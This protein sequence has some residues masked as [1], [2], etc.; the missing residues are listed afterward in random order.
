MTIDYNDDVHICYKGWYGLIY[1]FFDGDQ[2]FEETVSNTSNSWYESSIQVDSNNNPH[3][4]YYDHVNRSIM[5]AYRDGSNWYNQIVTDPGNARTIS[6]L[7]IDNNDNPHICYKDRNN[8]DLKYANFTG[9]EWLNET[10]DLDCSIGKGSIVVDS[11][12]RPHI[13]YRNMTVDSLSYAYFNDTTWLTETIDSDGDHV[14]AHNS[15]TLDRNDLPHISYSY[16]SY[17]ASPKSD[18]KYAYNNGTEWQI[19]TVDHFV[20]GY[21]TSVALD[22]ND[23]PHISYYA[24]PG[25]N[26]KHSTN[27][28]TWSDIF[29]PFIHSDN[30]PK[31]GTT[32]DVFQFNLSAFDN[33]ELESVYINWSQ[34]ESNHNQSLKFV[35]RIRINDNWI[36]NI[37]LNRYTT[38][39]LTYTIYLKDTSNNYKISE[40]KLIHVFDN[41]NP[42]LR[43]DF[44]T[45]SGTTGDSVYF[46]I[47]TEDNI[48]IDNVHINWTHGINN[49]NISLQQN[50]ISWIGTI[51]LSH[52]LEDFS[53][54][55]YIN[56]ASGNCYISEVKNVTI[57][58]NDM[59][60]ILIDY[61]TGKPTTGDP[62]RFTFFATDNIMLDEYHFSYT[63]DDK[64]Y[65]YEK[66]DRDGWNYS[67]NITIPDNSTG[68]SYWFNVSD[69]SRNWNNLTHEDKV[70][71]DNDP[72][73]LINDYTRDTPIAG[74]EFRISLDVSDN[75]GLSVVFLN[76][77][78]NHM[79]YETQALDF[80]SETDLWRCEINILP[81]AT[82]LIYHVY[83]KDESGN[84]LNTYN[85]VEKPKEVKDTTL[86][87]AEAGENV[88]IQQDSRIVFDA[89][90]SSDN[91]AITEWRWEFRYN[92]KNV[93]LDGNTTSYVFRESGRY[94]IS[95]YV[96]DEEGNVG[97]DWF[98]I[99][100]I[101]DDEEQ[102]DNDKSKVSFFTI[103][104]LII[105]LVVIVAVTVIF[106]LVYKH[107]TKNRDNK[108]SK[109]EKEQVEE[110]KGTVEA[111]LE[112]EVKENEK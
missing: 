82:S 110:A 92:K 89:S 71:L 84:L 28:P 79:T 25:G 76:Y 50:L 58:D 13:S 12:N 72:P 87:I 31:N 22:S 42:T 103:Y 88:T 41:D 30:S 68:V 96:T 52:I 100:V 109:T 10:V 101:E 112:E 36:R 104:K 111:I 67:L 2:L 40:K 35:D 64:K 94:K 47:Y 11:N 44:S 70:V 46:D 93:L 105:I 90:N 21:F 106:L 59:P 15:I 16:W 78:L 80:S 85:P 38:D 51:N 17:G 48:G 56:D 27:D 61:T 4:S 1:V 7:A 54:T 37:T 18:L 83:A 20:T 98:Y 53:Y 62:Y 34:G 23:Y 43:N 69:T 81:N 29:P 55:I 33:I 74:E 97:E 26:L 9:I 3:I 73:Q 19:E 32:G 49:G 95:L 91:I 66:M 14:G 86:P 108:M 99:T 102:N 77:S 60:E 57:T 107:R 5:Y 75:V 6:S 39:D 24:I 63:Y 65:W 8:G 45:E